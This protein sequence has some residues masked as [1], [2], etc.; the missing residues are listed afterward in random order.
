MKHET[1]HLADPP[2]VASRGRPPWMSGGMLTSKPALSIMALVQ[3]AVGYA[4]GA[5]TSSTDQQSL[6]RA[7]SQLSAAR[8]DLTAADARIERD[9]AKIRSAQAS[10]SS[11]SARAQATCAAREAQLAGNEKT[12]EQ[13]E[14]AVKALEGQIEASAISADG[15]Y[16]VGHDIKSGVWHT[17]GDGGQTDNACYYPTL[18]STDTSAIEDNN[19]FD[20]PETVSMTGVDAFEISGPCTW[21]RIGS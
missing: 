7:H 16:I 14:R 21:Y 20:G 17:V 11:A 9:Q 8:T 5:G 15:V 2:R 4:I 1:G 10:A 6:T 3:M 19:N 18:S 13:E 12:L